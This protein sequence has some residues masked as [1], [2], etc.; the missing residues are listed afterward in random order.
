MQLFWNIFLGLGTA[1]GIMGSFIV[2]PEDFGL[3]QIVL[4]WI[5]LIGAIAAGV[6]GAFGH[7]LFQK[8]TSNVGT[9]TQVK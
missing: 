5:R 6:G 8:G 3:S 1:I 9:T 2:K 7:S 4:N